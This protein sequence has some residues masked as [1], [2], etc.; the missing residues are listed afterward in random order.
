MMHGA[1]RYAAVGMHR[2]C[3][4][5]STFPVFFFFFSFELSDCILQCLNDGTPDVRDS[6]FSVLA[7][8]AKVVFPFKKNIENLLLHF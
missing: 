6:A 2:F 3:L 7:A 1:I 5:A 4:S 8:V